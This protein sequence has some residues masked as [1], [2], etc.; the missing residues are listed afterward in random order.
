MYFIIS[1]SILYFS[2]SSFL[3]LVLVMG[4]PP[5]FLFFLKLGLLFLVVQRGLF[6]LLFLFSTLLLF[7]KYNLLVEGQRYIVLLYQEFIWGFLFFS[8]LFFVF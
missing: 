2:G 1:F 3:S 8:L 6:L 7:Y 4:L 5:S